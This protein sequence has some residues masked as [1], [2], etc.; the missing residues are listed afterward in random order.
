MDNIM[1]GLPKGFYEHGGKRA[2]KLYMAINDFMSIGTLYGF[3]KALLSEVGYQNT[4]LTFGNAAKDRSYCFDDLAGRKLMLASDSLASS[5]R[6]FLSLKS[7]T[8]PYRMMAVTPV[9]RYR[10]K[11]YRRWH[12]LI[13]S[14]FDETD[15]LNAISTLF[16]VA[17]S[18]LREYYPT[19]RYQVFFFNIFEDA[20]A[21]LNMSR[22]EVFNSLY[23]RYQEKDLTVHNEADRFIEIIE[24]MGKGET[25]CVKTFDDIVD[26]YP[27]L[28]DAIDNCKGFIEFLDE[29]HIDYTVIWDSYHAIEYSSGICFLAYDERGQHVIADGGGYS[30]IV[31]KLNPTIQSCYSFACSLENLPSIE[32]GSVMPEIYLFGMGCSNTFFQKCASMLRGNGYIVKD[33]IVKGKLKNELRKIPKDAEAIVLGT[34]E[35]MANSFFYKNVRYSLFNDFD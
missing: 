27:E 16:S 30:Y 2:N 20:C 1:S 17:N 11:T 7:T 13:Y 26:K 33:R 32:K 25:D 22:E 6:F 14:M 34:D 29:S 9:Y 12:H 31:N 5:I 23:N 21:F 10:K 15:S 18:F 19:I 24:K 35:E 8:T 3:E 28:Q 4:Y